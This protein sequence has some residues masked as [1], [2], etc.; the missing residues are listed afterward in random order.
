MLKNYF[1]PALLILFSFQAFSQ[2]PIKLNSW[3]L[4]TGFSFINE[5][6]L[7]TGVGFNTGI[8]LQLT[9]KI[10]GIVNVEYMFADDIKQ[11]DRYLGIYNLNKNLS[12]V[13][14]DAGLENTIFKLGNLD[15]G[16]S[17]AIAFRKRNEAFVNLLYKQFPLE[18]TPRFVSETT[19]NSKWQLGNTTALKV[20]LNL[21][22]MFF[23]LNSS[24]QLFSKHSFL[25]SGLFTGL[26]F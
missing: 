25:S 10:I 8:D 7:K 12:Y 3:H 14:I 24:Y 22:R 13:Q 2:S 18:Q 23:G 11:D 16:I 15:L 4:G 1:L 6:Q 26:N 21:K 17:T 5:P 20:Q 19:Y 9:P